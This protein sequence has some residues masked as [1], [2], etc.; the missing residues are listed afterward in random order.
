MAVYFIGKKA[1]LTH[2]QLL[3][4]YLRVVINGKRFEI[5][6]HQHCDPSLW[7]PVAGKVKGNAD[8]VSQTNMALDEIRRQVY[9]YK[10]RIEKEGRMFSVQTLREKWFGQDRN[11]RTLLGAV[12]LNI[13]DLEK[14]VIKGIYKKST[15]TKYQTMEKHLAN[16][17]AWRNTGSDI[18][19]KDLKLPFAAHFVY[20][21][22]AENGMGVNSSAKMV[23]NLKKIVRDCVDKEWLDNDPFFRYK[24]KHIDPKVPHLTAQELQVLQS[25]E[26]SI[27]RLAVV[28]DIFLFSCYTGFAYV[29]VVNLTSDDLHIDIDG[30]DWLIKNRQK[31]NISERVPMFPVVASILAKYKDFRDKSLNKKLLPVPHQC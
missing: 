18:L 20:Y 11:L 25:K 16:F 10:E 12:R 26:I 4:I 29:D 17:L 6:T 5:A 3:P 31:T 21:L 14:Q 24:V 7:L 19:L 23:K 27:Q 1:R 13:L 8:S 15:L 28:R 2:H 30:K 9:D 22:Q